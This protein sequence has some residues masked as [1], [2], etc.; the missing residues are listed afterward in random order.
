MAGL[1]FWGVPIMD[2]RFSGPPT[3]GSELRK[4]VVEQVAYCN[5]QGPVAR[6]TV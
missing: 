2:D 4:I 3:Q 1:P 5:L 6:S